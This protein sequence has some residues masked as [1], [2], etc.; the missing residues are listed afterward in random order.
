MQPRATVIG[1]V[2][3]LFVSAASLLIFGII[4]LSRRDWI[5]GLV[6]ILGALISLGAGFGVL[7]GFRPLISKPEDGK[8]FAPEPPSSDK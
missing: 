3:C 6:M 2:V 5:L 1:G 7:R 8:G 4:I